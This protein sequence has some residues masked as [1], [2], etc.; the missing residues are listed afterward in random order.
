MR[1]AKR[2]GLRLAEANQS[3]R[4]RAGRYVSRGLVLSLAFALVLAST[5][6][7]ATGGAARPRVVENT[8][9]SGEVAHA[10]W[11]GRIAPGVIHRV[12]RKRKP[13]LVVHIVT[14]DLQGRATI[15]PALATGIL[16]GL[17]TTSSMARR[18]HAVA[19]INGDFFHPSGRPIA[20]FARKGRLAQ[21]ALMPGANFAVARADE[22]MF[23]GHRRITASVADL[24]T[25]RTLNVGRVNSGPPS[26]TGLALFTPD[27]GGL[28][29]P[30]KGACSARLREIG[31]YRA[32][33]D[34]A[35]TVPVRVGK[36]ACRKRRMTRAGTTVLSARWMGSHRRDISDLTRGQEM[37]I[38]WRTGWPNIEDVIGGNP[39]LIRNGR[40]EWD[41]LSG[42]HYIFARHPRSGVGLTDDG[43][44]LLVAVDGRRPRHSVGMTLTAFAKL[45]K[46][47]GATWA[48]NL[49]GGG[50]TTMVVRGRVVN[51]P[52]DRRERPVGSALLVTMESGGSQKTAALDGPPPAEPIAGG[53]D[54]PI[55]AAALDPA[56]IGGMASWLEAR[57]HLGPEL[58][59]VAERFDAQVRTDARR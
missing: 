47:L 33:L 57:G 56:S 10:G 21:T 14:A 7:P 11:G 23:I 54:A 19:A 50:S 52:S 3:G 55:E 26:T 22:V 37:S 59:G 2:I 18:R 28:E 49:D 27:G 17:E 42:S 15:R 25:G 44:V 43:K 32:D 51:K 36:V 1:T 12:I 16:P 41:S 20:A 5:W 40:I 4:G 8:V 31:P 6:R 53:S 45:F 35:M 24:E 34:G 39:V 13:R 38:T 48:L 9:A 46:S 58:L 29:L 30:P